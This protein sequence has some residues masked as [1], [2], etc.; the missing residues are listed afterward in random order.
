MTG[1]KSYKILLQERDA[2]LY[3]AEDWKKGNSSYH[4][5]IRIGLWSTSTYL[6]ELL[7]IRLIIEKEIKQVEIDTQMKVYKKYN[8]PKELIKLIS[9]FCQS[10]LD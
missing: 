9:S 1:L 3:E 10:V 4:N 5:N 2:I 7:Y 8:I 6:D